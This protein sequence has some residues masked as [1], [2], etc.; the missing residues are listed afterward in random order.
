MRRETFLLVVWVGMV[1]LAGEAAAEAVAVAAEAAVEAAR[2]AP[3][4]PFTPKDRS[5]FDDLY[6]PRIAKAT[7]RK[8]KA[9]LAKELLTAAGQLEGGL[10]YL[11]LTATKDLAT[12][13]GEAGIAV[14]AQQQLVEL[15][16]GDPKQ[17]RSDL[18]TLQ[19]KHFALLRRKRVS[20][21][22]RA[23]LKKQVFAL[24][25]D[26]VDVAIWLGN[27]YRAEFDFAASEKAERLA[28]TTA[29][30]VDSPRQ[31]QLRQGIVLSQTLKAVVARA[32]QCEARGAP[33]RAVW[34]YLDAGMYDRANA[35]PGAKGDADA[36]LLIRVGLN[37]AAQPA[38]LLAGAKSWDKRGTEARGAIQTVRLS[39]AADLY[40]RYLS[41]GAEEERQLAKVRLKA[42]S[43]KLG[44][45]RESF[46]PPTGWT[47]L[48]DLKEDSA[49][50]GWGSFKKYTVAKGPCNVTGRKF[51]TGMMVHAGSRVVYTLRGR[52]RQLSIHYG[53]A[54]WAGGA[55]SFHIYCDGKEVFKSGGM[56]K[57]HTH[58]VRKPT[59][60]NLVGVDKLE[61]VTKGIAGGQGAHSMWG[62][63]KVR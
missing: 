17:L 7:S 62:D 49:R 46:R 19:L 21:R 38:D 50:V 15:K 58:G 23:A 10:K 37:A 8:A 63:P 4:P 57:N 54:P 3:G 41:G 1:L 24:G 14:T 27:T 52:Y 26:L 42:I 56:W 30:L 36:A 12:S 25:N 18:L 53:M 45:L 44:D 51:T 22:E 35:L 34:E 6:K 61:L 20:S 33:E 13:G 5:S 2:P 16:R 32:K 39:R 47:Y 28:V 48:V 55:A 43:E 40:E 29:R 11:L 59:F 31:A 9:A 60:V